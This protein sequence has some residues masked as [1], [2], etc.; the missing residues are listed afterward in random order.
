MG[1]ALNFFGW[2]LIIIGVF[3]ILN[4]SFN[5]TGFFILDNLNKSVGSFLGIVFVVGGI[6]V[7]MIGR[8]DREGLENR[9]KV[10]HTILQR[11][12]GEYYIVNKDNGRGYSLKDIKEYVKDD[13]LKR[14]LRN[15][16]LSDLLKLYAESNSDDKFRYKFFIQ[17][18][19]PH[20]NHEN[21]NKRLKQ[22]ENIYARL[23]DNA[24][25]IDPKRIKDAKSGDFND[26]L[27][28]RFENER[29]TLWPEEGS[30]V[31][32]PFDEGKVNPA[33]GPLFSVIPVKNLVSHVYFTEDLRLN[34]Q[35]SK[36]KRK[37]YL[38]DT[39]GIDVGPTQR[40]IIFFQIE[41]G[42]KLEEFG[43][44]ENVIIENKVPLVKVIKKK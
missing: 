18:L 21:L 33:R 25:D 30:I 8:G 7:A 40:S 10:E 36:Q 31:F 19:S 13:D 26:R 15:E 16:Y 27:Y 11:R 1:K 37:D 39:Y 6:L 32:M 20:S 17:A 44:Y 41:K 3:L 34:P 43:K 14:E 5:I 23:K 12:N 22:F 9:L 2:S 38:R 28:T 4:S 42:A 24:Q 35:W 29:D